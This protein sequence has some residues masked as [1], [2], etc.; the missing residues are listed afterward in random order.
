MLDLPTNFSKLLLYLAWISMSWWCQNKCKLSLCLLES[1][2]SQQLHWYSPSWPALTKLVLESLQFRECYL[3]LLLLRKPLLHIRHENIIS[4][5]FH[6]FVSFILVTSSLKW[7]SFPEQALTSYWCWR[8][9][10]SERSLF[11]YRLIEVKSSVS[12]TDVFENLG[13]CSFLTT[14]VEGPLLSIYSSDSAFSDFWSHS[15]LS[16][17]AISLGL[18]Y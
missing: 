3:R 18:K 16:W 5:P 9:L 6:S 8:S 7:N 14:D 11:R 4:W 1:V 12:P 17:S 13:M 2:T 10:N 15:F